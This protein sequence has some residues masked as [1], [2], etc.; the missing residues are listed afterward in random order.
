MKRSGIING[1]LS[2]ALAGLRHTDVFVVCDAGLSAPAGANVF[3]LAIEY[4]S[5]VVTP[6]L[7]A[8]LDEV[9]VEQAWVASE[10]ADRNPTRE[11]EVALLLAG[12]PVKAA[13]HDQLRRLLPQARFFIRTGDDKPYSNVVLRAGV[14]FDV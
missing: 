14:G 9:V 5:P 2:G 1:P 13:P 6:V 11:S 10:M 7:R 8:V 4:G 3:D 12:I